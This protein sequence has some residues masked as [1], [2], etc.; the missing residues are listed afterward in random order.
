MQNVRG[1]Q[2]NEVNLMKEIKLNETEKKEFENLKKQFSEAKTEEERSEI[3]IE[4]DELMAR[5]VGVERSCTAYYE[6]KKR[7]VIVEEE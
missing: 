7:C 1:S 5:I 3:I 2:M 4:H 6:P